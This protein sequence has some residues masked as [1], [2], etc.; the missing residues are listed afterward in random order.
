M[1][2][3]NGDYVYNTMMNHSVYQIK[4]GC[5]HFVFTYGDKI[6][7]WLKNNEMRSFVP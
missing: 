1:Y 4:Q 7:L 3:Q 6:E 2:S 5:N